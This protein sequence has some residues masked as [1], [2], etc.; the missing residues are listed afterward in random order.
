MPSTWLRCAALAL[1]LSL[2]PLM[3]APALAQDAGTARTQTRELRPPEGSLRRG[4]WAA[5]RWALYLG[6]GASVIL[7]AA[8]LLWRARRRR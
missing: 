8:A 6:G 4:A 7:A 3:T 2:S 1:A 5:P